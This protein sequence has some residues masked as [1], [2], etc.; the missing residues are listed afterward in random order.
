MARKKSTALGVLSLAPGDTSEGVGRRESGLEC[1]GLRT[2]RH[3]ASRAGQFSRVWL[4]VLVGRGDALFSLQ[5]VCLKMPGVQRWDTLIATSVG[6][7]LLVGVAFFLSLAPDILWRGV[8]EDWLLAPGDA[9]KVRRSER[10]DV[11]R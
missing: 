7:A 8:L 5:S 4:E 9:S 2:F 6:V 3:M 1:E 11:K 10:W